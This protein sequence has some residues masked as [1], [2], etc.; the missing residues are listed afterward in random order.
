MRARLIYG[1]AV[2]L[3]MIL[4]LASR[5]YGDVLP[6]FIAQHLGDALWAGMIYF[7]FRMLLTRHPEWWCLMISLVFSFGIEA[8]QL[9]Q[10]E[11]ID[12][13]RATLPGG[14][15]LGRG[16]LWIDLLRYTAGVVLCYALD[17]R[18]LRK[19]L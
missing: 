10:G 18:L 17:R 3:A 14:L 1:C 19:T 8:S 9:Y 11:W 4:G 13:L 5:V 6:T 16:F 12:G 7:A 15:I 2:L